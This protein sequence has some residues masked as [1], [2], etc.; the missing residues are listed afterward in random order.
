[1]KVLESRQWKK[2][3]G[4]VRFLCKPVALSRPARHSHFRMRERP[5]DYFVTTRWS[6][7]L[8]AGGD[9]GLEKETALA[10]FCRDYW[11]PVFIYIRRHGHDEEAARDLTQ[12]FFVRLVDKDWLKDV[13]P[14]AAKFRAFLLTAVKR[15][16]AGE[17]WRRTALKRGGG[18]APLSLDKEDLPPMASPELTPEQAFDRQWALAVINRAMDHLRREAESSGRSQL[19]KEL[20]EFISNEPESGDYSRPATALGLSRTAV[21]MTVHRMRLR[22]R[23]LVRAEV[24]ETLDDPRLVE[25]ELRELMSALRG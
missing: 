7:V 11:Q 23:E 17:Y 24:A 12:E 10:S 5:D 21:A 13:T 6:V 16:L 20:A 8:K 3:A 4:Q 14:D 15:F 19:F 2:S 9:P 18:T 1:M 22:L 25:S